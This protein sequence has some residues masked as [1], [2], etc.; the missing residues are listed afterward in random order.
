VCSQGATVDVE[1]RCAYFEHFAS[2]ND[3]PDARIA[4][5]LKVGVGEFAR[6]IAV[7]VSISEYANSQFNLPAAKIDAYNL[8]HFL[9]EDQKFDEVII[10][11]N[12]SATIENIRYF[13]RTYATERA[14][15]Y[16]GK[17]RFLFAFSGHGVPVQTVGDVETSTGVRPSVGLALA[18]AAN[19]HDLD[20]IYGLNELRPLFTDLAKNTYHFLALINA[21]YGGD[22]FGLSMPGGDTNDPESRSSEGIT[23]GPADDTVISLG[24][25][26]GSLFFETL[27]KG[28]ESGDADPDARNVTLGFMPQPQKYNGIVRL[29]ALDTYL[30]TQIEKTIASGV[31]SAE[32]LSGNEHHWIG[33]IVPDG[34]RSLGGFFFL[35]HA[36]IPNAPPNPPTI[37]QVSA[38]VASLHL[39]KSFTPSLNQIALSPERD[40]GFG[41]LRQLPGEKRGVDVSRF[42]GAIDWRRVANADIRFAYIKSTGSATY[43]D[44][45]FRSNWDGTKAAG[46]LRGAYHTF[47]FCTS[48]DSQLEN[49]RRVVPPDSDALPFALD[50]DLY[51]GQA[52]ATVSFLGQEG[53]CA[54]QLGFEGIRRAVSIMIAG[55]K[56][57]YGSVPVLYGNNYLLDEVLGPDFTKQI[58]LWRVSLGVRGAPTPPWTLWQF[59]SNEFVGGIKHPVDVNVLSEKIDLEKRTR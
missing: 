33:P 1:A 23:A 57:T 7:V 37:G 12:Q 32:E 30:S 11:E 55:L 27:I 39:G 9:I 25:G 28:I 38:Y 19:D 5:N 3:P 10:L 4:R 8:K 18:N 42:S 44:Q 47:S 41:R 40:D 24:A 31:V 35:Q 2:E 6:S 22:L 50:I 16:G 43:A 21:C 45:L 59:T 15:F 13:L 17:V 14:A 52:N 29:G 51:E 53:R 26:H 34:E 54:E 56:A 58:T 20:N 49:I 48:P 36:P 46:L